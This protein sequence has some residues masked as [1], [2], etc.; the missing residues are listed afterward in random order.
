MKRRAAGFTIVELLI[1]IVVIAILAAIS[2][3]AYSGVHQRAQQAKMQ[4]DTA[5]A[6]KNIQ[7]FA[8]DNGVYPG[9]INDCPSPS[10]TNLC[11]PEAASGELYYSRA[12]VGGVGNSRNVRSY[13]VAS[14]GSKHFFYSSPM[15]IMG[16]N[17]FL[18]YTDVAPFIDRYGLVRYR[19]EFDIKSADISSR[20][21]VNVYFQN[22]NGTKHNGLS[23]NIPVTT[24]YV[25]HS[26]TFTPYVSNS[27][28][29]KSIL[30]FY[31]TYHTGNIPSVRNVTIQLAQ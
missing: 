13:E 25:R 23:V 30:A 18:Q 5:Q 27:S 20:N 3:V 26:V 10:S 8:A 21:L 17:E 15:E 9:V 6:N 7:L 22:G 28:F 31:G 11:M 2:V 24:S 19:I 29:D 14:L 4:A 1:V 16:G 12:P